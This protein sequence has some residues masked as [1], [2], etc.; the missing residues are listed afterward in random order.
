MHVISIELYKKMWRVT[1]MG[2]FSN[3]ESI[4]PNKYQQ[5]PPPKPTP[6]PTPEPQPMPVE[7]EPK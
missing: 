4:E 5:P 2:N 3:K 7:P 6:E 1:N